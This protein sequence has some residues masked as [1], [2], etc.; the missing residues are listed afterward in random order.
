MARRAVRAAFS[1]ATSVAGRCTC[2]FRPCDN[3][4]VAFVAFRVA[5]MLPTKSLAINGVAEVADFRAIIKP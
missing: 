1:G 3:D 2:M 4:N 5:E